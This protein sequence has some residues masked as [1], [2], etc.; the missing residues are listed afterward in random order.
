MVR[1]LQVLT[2]N[3]VMEL[4]LCFQKLKDWKQTLRQVVPLRKR[5]AEGDLERDEKEEKE[6]S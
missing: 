5:A 3:Q 2:V 6:E 1:L 4:L